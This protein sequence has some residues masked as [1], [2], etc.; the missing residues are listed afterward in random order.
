ME[1]E[2]RPDGNKCH[3]HSTR[4]AVSLL[5]E[6]GEGINF[7]AKVERH[8]NQAQYNQAERGHPFKIA[9]DNALAKS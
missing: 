3:N 7:G 6:L 8:E 9:D 1:Q 5:K 2:C 4:C